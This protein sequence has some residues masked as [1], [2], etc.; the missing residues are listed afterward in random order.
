M[1]KFNF[2]LENDDID[3]ETQLEVQ[4][5][6][7]K[8]PEASSSDSHKTSIAFREHSLETLLGDL[9]NVLSFSPITVPLWDG[10]TTT[11]SR[12]DLFDAKFQL[13]QQDSSEPATE[14]STDKAP[15]D[16]DF[17][18]APSDLVPGVYEGGLK[19]WECSLDLV[20]CLNDIF[21]NNTL[22]GK[23]ILEVGC[24]TAIPSIYILNKIF[25]LPLSAAE[26]VVHLQDYNELVFRLVTF[27]NV[28][29]A[30]YMSP[31]S[32]SFR[33]ANPPDPNDDETDSFPSSDPKEQGDLPITPTLKT[34]FLESLKQ[35]NI[36]LRFCSGSWETFNLK[37]SGGK[38]DI[39][40][41]SETI[42]QMDSLPSLVKLLY[43]ASLGDEED[44]LVKDTQ[45]KLSI[46]ETER[47]Y[48]CLVAAKFVYFGV[49]G[50]VIDFIQAVEEDPK[51]RKGKVET[52]WE[53][54]EG[55]KRSVMKVTWL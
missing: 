50:G 35:Y 51:R 28:V 52:V 36:T 46:S 31:A 14:G 19:T 40:L 39:I 5:P 10:Q 27:P 18:E 7:E 20:G 53:K 38:Y 15:T 48:L 22:N 25:S 12:R 16:I 13:I 44:S 1:F 9:P 49:G 37:T 54:K 34:A 4:N 2:D 47:S 3:N 24:G 17:L 32:A 55:V 23:R 30:W 26:T 33:E 11:L 21:G 43:H 42:Y 45:A 29:L 41:T 8:A 6:R